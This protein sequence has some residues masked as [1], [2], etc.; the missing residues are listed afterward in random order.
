M[1]RSNGSKAKRPTNLSP[2][3]IPCKVAP[4]MFRGEYLVYVDAAEPS[5][6][7]EKATAQLLVDER[8]VSGIVGT[9]KRNDPVNGW[10][11]ATLI[12]QRGEWAEV[13]LPQPSQPFGERILVA[14]DS[15]REIQGSDSLR[16]SH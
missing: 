12:G 7:N 10:L 9:P 14:Y 3:R 16:S 4:G 2:C 5:N 15:V 6:P 13:V 1:T 11:R 8:E